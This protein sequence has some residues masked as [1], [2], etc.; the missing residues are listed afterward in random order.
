MGALNQDFLQS[1]GV[2]FPS[3]Q[4]TNLKKV[5]QEG[6]SRGFREAAIGKSLPFPTGVAFLDARPKEWPSQKREMDIR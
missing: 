6:H 4:L 5:F 1:P 3:F 2:S